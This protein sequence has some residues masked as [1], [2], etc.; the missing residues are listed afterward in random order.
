MKIR[1]ILNAESISYVVS[2]QKLM[3]YVCVWLYMYAGT[4]LDSLL[5]LITA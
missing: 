4:C 1:L 2:M 3:E 5:T